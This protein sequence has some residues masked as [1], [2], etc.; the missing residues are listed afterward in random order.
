MSKPLHVADSE[1]FVPHRIVKVGVATAAGSAVPVPADTVAD[2]VGKA[3]IAK[4]R[5]DVRDLPKRE[6]VIKVG[7]AGE[8]NDSLSTGNNKVVNLVPNKIGDVYPGEHRYAYQLNAG[9]K[10]INLGHP[11]PEI[12]RWVKVQ[13]V[14]VVSIDGV[15]VSAEIR[16][17]SEAG[18]ELSLGMDANAQ[19]RLVTDQEEPNG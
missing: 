2:P 3:A 16:G 11:T 10:I 12:G 14:E 7:A 1:M 4:I 8:A 17:V 15:R 18:Y 9:D 6:R 5:E 19:I 13:Q